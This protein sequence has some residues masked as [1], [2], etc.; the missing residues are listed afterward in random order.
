MLKEKARQVTRRGWRW[1]VLAAAGALALGV[2]LPLTITGGEPGGAPGQQPATLTIKQRDQLP[3]MAAMRA[4][5]GDNFALVTTVGLYMAI[6]NSVAGGYHIDALL[7]NW[8]EVDLCRLSW[9]READVFQGND[10][11]HSCV[12]EALRTA[13]RRPY[14][15]PYEHD[16][17][18]Q[19]AYGA[20]HEI[21]ITTLD[22][23]SWHPQLAV[24]TAPCRVGYRAYVRTVHNALVDR[25]SVWEFVKD[26]FNV[27]ILQA[28]NEAVEPTEG[29]GPTATSD[30]RLTSVPATENTT[31]TK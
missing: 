17:Q 26:Q 27:C 18:L 1:M 13:E 4:A 24:T 6:E 10:A 22:P 15:D 14:Q 2:A 25:M 11:I 7:E 8:N 12:A 20:L 29:P 28:R 3:P 19:G 5:H 31:P 21:T 30:P 9:P 16:A 23:A